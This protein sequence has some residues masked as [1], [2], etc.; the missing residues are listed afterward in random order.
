[1]SSDLRTPKHALTREEW[2]ESTC[3]DI[4]TS[5]MDFT[6][7]K[8][9]PIAF[10][11]PAS[12]FMLVVPMT[13]S[14][15]SMP[16]ETD[17]HIAPDDCSNP[18]K[19]L[20]FFHQDMLDSDEESEPTFR[21]LF[22]SENH[23][24]PPLPRRVSL[25]MQPLLENDEFMETF[26]LQGVPIETSLVAPQ[27]DP[28]MIIKPSPRR[29]L[30]GEKRLASPSLYRKKDHCGGTNTSSSSDFPLQLMSPTSTL[31]TPSFTTPKCNI[32]FAGDDV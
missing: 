24:T 20:P 23:S 1:M 30:T 28:S 4:S 21:S 32:V 10:A 8:I 6:T 7:H 22:T 29:Y 13:M 16:Q 18:S 19:M 26:E 31:A 2:K 12:A 25:T 5:G 11:S 17:V 27:A 15:N 9:T 3:Y 14:S